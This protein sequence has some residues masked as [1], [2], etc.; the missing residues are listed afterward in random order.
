MTKP[1]GRRFREP[2]AD[3]RAL[4][5]QA[6]EKLAAAFAGDDAVTVDLCLRAMER[7]LEKMTIV[8]GED[9]RV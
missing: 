3:E 4:L 1:R 9:G 7:V 5:A 6:R 2:T 8:N